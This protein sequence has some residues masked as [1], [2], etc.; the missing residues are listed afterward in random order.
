M[1]KLFFLILVL[2]LFLCCGA[3]Q[4]KVEKIMEDGVEVV[5]NNIEP[6]RIT[7]EPTTFNLEE[8]VGT[9]KWAIIGTSAKNG[10]GIDE[11]LYFLSKLVLKINIIEI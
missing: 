8:I 11:F 3:K 7:G 1:K 6:Y 4:E 10:Y 5:L 9:R 2:S